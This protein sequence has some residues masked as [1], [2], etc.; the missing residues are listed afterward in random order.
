[1]TQAIILRMLAIISAL[2]KISER[3]SSAP[4]VVANTVGLLA[5]VECFEFAFLLVFWNTDLH[6]TC[7]LSSYLQKE[8]ID[9]TTVVNLMDSYDQ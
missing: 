1:M 9:L 5:T 4:K 3:S 2:C 8:S 6:T 7:V